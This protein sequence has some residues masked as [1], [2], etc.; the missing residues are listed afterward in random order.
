M[1]RIL[2]FAGA[3][4]ALLLVIIAALPF[5]IP[6]SVYKAQIEKAASNALGRPVAVEGDARISIFP[7]IS[8]SVED[9][10]VANPDGF[11]DEDMITAGTLR[12][13]VRLLPLFSRRVEVAEIA[14]E[15]ATVR[16][17]RLEDGS[18]NWQLGDAAEA[19]ADPKEQT[20]ANPF[21][22]SIDTARL[23]NAALIYDDRQSGARYELSNLDAETSLKSAE[24]PMTL[25]ANGDF[26]N[27]AFDLSLTL[28]TPATLMAGAKSAID[29]RLGSN[30]GNLSFDGELTN[31]EAFSVNGRFSASVPNITAI[32]SFLDME[33]P[34]NAAPLGGLRASGSMK[35]ALP[36]LS[37]AFE[38]LAL[39]GDGLSAVY[40]GSLNLA[41]EPVFDGEARI[42]VRDA[43]LLSEQLGMPLAALKTVK[44]LSIDTRV[45]GPLSKLEFSGINARTSS[46]LLTAS[47]SG[48]IGLEGNGLLDGEVSA[49]T[50]QFRQLV[51]QLGVTLPAGENMKTA[52]M[53]GRALGSFQHPGIQNG[54]F[55]ID[56]TRASGSISAN[57]QGTT[58]SVKASLEAPLLDLS[59]FLG[60]PSGPVS[61]PDQESDWSDTPLDLEALSLVD[62]DL[63]LA[64]DEIRIGEIVLTNSDFGISLKDGRL[65]ADLNRFTAFGGNWQGRSLIDASAQIPAFDFQMTASSVQAGDLLTGLAGFDRLTGNGQ[66]SVDVSSAG[67]SISQI[68]D[69]VDGTLSLDLDSGALAGINLGQLIRSAGSLTSAISSGELSLQSLGDVVSP[70]AQTDFTDF[71]TV[72]E[73]QD[74]LARVSSLSLI[75]SVLDVTGTGEIN[76]AGRTLDLKLAPAIDKTGQGQTASI[77]VNGIPVPLRVHGKWSSPKFT[78]DFSGV[79]AALTT[80][81]RDKAA[82]ELQN[83]IGGDLGAI[84]SDV[85]SGRKAGSDKS[86]QETAPAPEAEDTNKQP[87]AD[88]VQ[89]PD[90]EG[91]PPESTREQAIRDV[92]GSIFGPD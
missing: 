51:T 34:V 81:A 88:D 52:S 74:G 72:L 17:T 47:F 15:D 26:Q 55:T 64:A 8:A 83:R 2:I 65:N 9:V 5:F 36:E 44:Q 10:R 91:T 12:G 37:V 30:L 84:A 70:Q 28:M 58:P 45:V 4:L 6:A 21:S 68:I 35:G 77:Q 48:L 20:G 40:N 18:V 7:V 49:K 11:D 19:E 63:A 69:A 75:N 27:E 39:S 86:S 89:E 29:A 50:G 43:Y 57:L 80:S 92:F 32:T 41:R 23:T 53:T 73:L 67:A 31:S 1:K 59:P 46:P 25:R 13:S 33:L 61:S 71:T 90:E 38:E 42:S 60:E 79:Q 22:A 85:I 14:F 82:A 56:E 3:G 76:L 87:E 78:P 66:F 24:K 16:L 54:S 62:A